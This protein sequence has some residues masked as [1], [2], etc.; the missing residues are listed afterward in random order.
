VTTINE[1]AR[2]DG[3]TTNRQTNMRETQVWC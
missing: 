2:N 1:N 3:R